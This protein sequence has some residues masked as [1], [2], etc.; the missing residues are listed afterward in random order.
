MLRAAVRRST[1]PRTSSAT[2]KPE[3]GNAK[4]SCIAKVIA[5]HDIATRDA[6]G[7]KP[8]VIVIDLD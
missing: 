5:A 1:Q 3:L 2:G 8:G 4:A 6:P 7:R